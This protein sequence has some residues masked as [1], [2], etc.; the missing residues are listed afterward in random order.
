MTGN[1]KMYTSLLLASGWWGVSR[2]M[3]YV[4]EIVLALCWSLPAGI[5]GWI[6]YVYVA[7]LTILLTD[8]AYRDEV[9]CSL[10][11]GRFYDEYCRMVPWKMIPGVY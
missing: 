6:P 5:G 8:R 9:R 7:F 1:G 2:H 4:F 10:K 11:Y 3:N